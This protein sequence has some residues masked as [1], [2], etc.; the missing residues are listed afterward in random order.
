[1]KTLKLSVNNVLKGAKVLKQLNPTNAALELVNRLMINEVVIKSD[2]S[3]MGLEAHKL[4]ASRSYS[5][6]NIDVVNRN[7]IDVKRVKYFIEQF[8]NG[9]FVYVLGTSYVN[10]VQDEN[11][12]TKLVFRDGV[13]KAIAQMLLGLPVVYMILNE[14]VSADMM[15]HFNSSVNPKWSVNDH[16]S[17]ALTGGYS[18]AIEFD[19]IINNAVN[20]YGLAVSKIKPSELYG[21]IKQNTKH[22]GGGMAA[23]KRS[24]YN[25]NT[26]AEQTKS[27][28]FKDLLDAF[29]RIKIAFKHDRDCYKISKETF[30][31]HFNKTMSFNLTRFV[32][33]IEQQ[34][35]V[36]DSKV[37][38]IRK[39]ILRVS[40]I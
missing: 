26:L 39:E 20:Q 4:Y 14:T 33:N 27:E 30:N 40:E 12:K 37:Q 21:L 32:R 8:Q 35:I 23:P 7:G 1:M 29:I 34:K 38:T 31:L 5:S 10:R 36:H 3:I 22:F 16:F 19:K 17:S 24:D 28:Q 11:G 13:H 18:L 15:A 9:T 2:A 25:S 6:F